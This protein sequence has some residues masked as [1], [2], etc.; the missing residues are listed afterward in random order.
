MSKRA[1]AGTATV[2]SGE[3]G[4]IFVEKLGNTNDLFSAKATQLTSGDNWNAGGEVKWATQETID[5]SKFTHSTT[6]NAHQITVDADGDYLLFYSDV[7]NSP[8]PDPIQRF[9][10]ASTETISRER[11]CPPITF[12]QLVVTITRRALFYRVTDCGQMMSFQFLFRPN[13]PPV[14][15]TILNPPVWFLSKNLHFP[16]RHYHCPNFRKFTNFGQRYFQAGRFQCCRHWFH[17]IRHH[18]NQCRNFQ[19]LRVR[20]YLHL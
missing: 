5:S 2:I 14:G 10:Y 7:L 20:T 13:L 15:W 9:W 6:S 11:K 8:W 3:K 18:C 12:V 17:R 4:S 16:R 1:A 19:F